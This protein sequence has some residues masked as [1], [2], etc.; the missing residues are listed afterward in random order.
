VDS[1]HLAV[2]RDGDAE[3]A[4]STIKQRTWPGVTA[5]HMDFIMIDADQSRQMRDKD[6]CDML[7]QV[8]MQT[9]ERKQCQNEP[10]EVRTHGAR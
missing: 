9:S 10:S 3:G 4:R 2:H 8:Q 1:Y 7:L 5:I 6:N